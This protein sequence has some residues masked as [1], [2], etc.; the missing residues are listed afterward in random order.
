MQYVWEDVG[1]QDGCIRKICYLGPYLLEH[2]ES[3]W[4]TVIATQPSEVL[5]MA[6]NV[7]L[8]NDKTKLPDLI[9]EL[10]LIEYE[11]DQSYKCLEDW[12]GA[13]VLFEKLFMGVEKN[14][15]RKGKR[16]QSK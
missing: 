4:Q 9:A 12:Y 6:S 16:V 10:P 13:N 5:M 15:K 3:E 11:K 7:Y 1:D 2:V 8:W 14:G